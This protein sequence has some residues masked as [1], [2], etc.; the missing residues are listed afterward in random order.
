MQSISQPETSQN[1]QNKQNKKQIVS[2]NLIHSSKPNL[3][4]QEIF[5]KMNPSLPSP[6]IQ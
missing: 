2:N 5:I 1:K 6:S 3:L 4:T